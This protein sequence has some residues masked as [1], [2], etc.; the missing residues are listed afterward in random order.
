MPPPAQPVPARIA[1]ADGAFKPDW[2]SLQRY[3]CPEWFRDAKLGF[4][5]ILG[6]QSQ[7]GDDS[8][9]ARKMYIEGGPAYRFHLE[10]FGHPSQFGYKDLAA[11]WK[12]RSVRP[13][14]A[15]GTLQESRGEIFRGA[16]H[17]SRQLGQLE[18]QI[19]PVELR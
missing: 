8:W 1:V 3:Q 11:Q 15:H 4:W 6:P 19:P 12:S 9:Y 2:D 14:P 10:H 18:F 16:R 17:F 13:G 5:G 7:A